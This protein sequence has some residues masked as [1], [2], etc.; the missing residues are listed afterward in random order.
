M[1]GKEPK[2]R[3]KASSQGEGRGV[4]VPISR[5]QLEEAGIDPNEPVEVNRYV[6]DDDESIIRLRLYNK[7]PDE[8]DEEQ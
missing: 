7:D 1:P 3:V 5:G 4:L 6:F 8:E 2:R